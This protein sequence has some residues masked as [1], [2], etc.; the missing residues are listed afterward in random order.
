MRQ[1]IYLLD[2]YDKAT[3]LKTAYSKNRVYF[4]FSTPVCF[5]HF[6]S[7]STTK[8]TVGNYCLYIYSSFAKPQF[9]LA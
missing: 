6:I 3:L 8:A 1:Q 9:I 2:I 5:G 7:Y 4:I